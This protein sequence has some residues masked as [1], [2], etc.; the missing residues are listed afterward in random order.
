MR[1]GGLIPL[2]MRLDNLALWLSDSTII[3]PNIED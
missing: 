3:N 1:L 2:A